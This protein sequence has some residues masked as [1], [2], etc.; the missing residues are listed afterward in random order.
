MA[1]QNK[2]HIPDDLLSAMHEAARADGKTPDEL[3]A[4]ALQQYLA[5]RK[6]EELG[7][8]GREQSR[9]LGLTEYDVPRL[10]AESRR[11]SPGR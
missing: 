7:K 2:V 4:D 1:V 8:Y 10:I 9:W 6:L 3:A 5:H 11:G